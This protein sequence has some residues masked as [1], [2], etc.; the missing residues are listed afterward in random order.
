[1]SFSISNVEN[2][3]YE[4]SWTD[5]LGVCVLS[6][7]FPVQYELIL[8]KTKVELENELKTTLANSS[9]YLKKVVETD[10]TVCLPDN[11]LMSDAVSNYYIE[12]LNTATYHNSQTKQPTF[13]ADDRGHSAA[14]LFQGCIEE[15]SGYTLDIEQ[16]LYGFNS[17]HYAL[18]LAKWLAYCQ[19]VDLKVFFAIEEEQSD[20]LKALLIAQSQD[21]GFNHMLSLVIPNDFVTNPSCRIKGSLNAYIPTQNI[22][23][24]Y[25]EYVKKPKKKIW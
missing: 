12:S 3:F 13:V 4:V 10:S 24:L 1:M 16:N 19:T 14:N 5:D 18:P 22:K 8:N 15:V 20:C 11:C 9:G 23:D 7:A 6:L 2:K 21:L 25:Q 17:T